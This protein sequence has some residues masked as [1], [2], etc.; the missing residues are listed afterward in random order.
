MDLKKIP[1][2]IALKYVADGLRLYFVRDGVGWALRSKMDGPDDMGVRAFGRVTDVELKKLGLAVGKDGIVSTIHPPAWPSDPISRM[3]MAD[4]VLL[5][6]ARENDAKCL[7]A[8]LTLL[9][10]GYPIPE[11]NAARN[12]PSANHK[13]AN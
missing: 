1:A 7:D 5:L 11:I 13:S 3:S 8:L 10:S 9:R 6:S 12:S 4:G 2:V